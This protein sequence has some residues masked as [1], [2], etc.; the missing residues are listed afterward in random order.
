MDEDKVKVDCKCG[1]KEDIL[2]SDYLKYYHDNPNKMCTYSI[3]CNNCDDKG[4]I[5]YYHSECKQFFC[6]GCQEH[7]CSYYD[8][9]VPALKASLIGAGLKLDEIKESIKKGEDFINTYFPS[10]KESYLSKETNKE[11]V[12]TFNKV[13]DATIANNKNILEF[14]T[15]ML[16]SFKKDNGNYL[17]NIEENSNINIYKYIE[18]SKNPD[19]VLNYLQFFN[20]TLY[21]QGKIINSEYG[22]NDALFLNDGNLLITYHKDGYLVGAILERMTWKVLKTW[23]ICSNVCCECVV[24][25]ENNLVLLSIQ[26]KYIQ[27]WNINEEE[28]KLLFKFGDFQFLEEIGVVSNNRIVTQINENKFAVWSINEPFSKEPIQYL[29]YTNEQIKGYYFDKERNILILNCKKEFAVFNT[30]TYQKITIIESPSEIETMFKYD[31]KM[32]YVVVEMTSHYF[33]L[34]SMT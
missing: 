32:Y 34:I 15:I 8:H 19:Y 23:N 17:R 4:V 1:Y 28:P 26:G 25:L 9:D 13:Y 2:L 3:L 16:N 6:E 22:Y 24:Q 5:K 33:I 21:K 18:D 10:L 14:I 31:K 7:Y 30:E 20:F 11:K 27:I 29:D 12:D